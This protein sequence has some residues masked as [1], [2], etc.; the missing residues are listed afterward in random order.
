MTFCESVQP[1]VVLKTNKAV[2][3]SLFHFALGPGLTK[4]W[5]LVALPGLTAAGTATVLASI[6]P[7]S[8]T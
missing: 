4:T 8:S 1:S 2:S 5:T 6:N 7:E 3:P